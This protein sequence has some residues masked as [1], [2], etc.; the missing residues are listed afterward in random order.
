MTEPCVVEKVEELAAKLRLD[1]LAE[2]EVLKEPE[3]Q[4]IHA[5][6]ADVR[7]PGWIVANVVAEVREDTVPGIARRPWHEIRAWHNVN[8]RP[9]GPPRDFVPAVRELHEMLG[10]EPPV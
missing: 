10:L 6:G 7:P 8:T 2:L 5:A 1:M 3:V 4:L 9:R